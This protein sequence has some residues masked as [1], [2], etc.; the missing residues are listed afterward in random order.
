[1]IVVVDR[2]PSMGLYGSELPYLSKPT[3]LREALT[4]IV[5]SA[6]AARAYVGYLDVSVDT[7]GTGGAV[8]ATPHWIAPHRQS[9]SRI[10]ARLEGRFEAPPES[11]ELALDYLLT[12][13]R[14]V[15]TGSFVFV[16]SDFLRAPPPELWFQIRARGWDCVPVIIQDP[17]WEQSFPNVQGLLVPFADPA[18]GKAAALRLTAKDVVQRRQ[19]NEARLQELLTGFQRLRFDP[20]LLDRADAPTIDLAFISWAT[21][22]RLARGRA[23]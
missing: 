14:D 1:M 4:T 17:T 2:R 8:Q 12:L 19:A 22:R 13:R 9:V 20:V 21:G 23:A 11:L 18:T 10:F 3:V 6:H 16:L 7:S 15:P 5:A